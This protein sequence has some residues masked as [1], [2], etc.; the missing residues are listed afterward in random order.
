MRLSS[1]DVKLYE[2]LIN[3]QKMAQQCLGILQL[4]SFFFRYAS[5]SEFVTLGFLVSNEICVFL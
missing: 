4:C 2:F 1:F 3:D 5:F